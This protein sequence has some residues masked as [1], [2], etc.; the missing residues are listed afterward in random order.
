MRLPVPPNLHRCE[1]RLARMKISIY[2]P[3]INQ[4]FHFG[5][6]S[7]S[8]IRPTGLFAT[9][10]YTSDA[11]A[12][13]GSR[14]CAF[15]MEPTGTLICFPYDFSDTSPSPCLLPQVFFCWLRT[16]PRGQGQRLD[17]PYHGPEESPCQMALR[18]QQPVI[19]GVFH[20][21]TAC[22]HQPLLQARQRVSDQF[23]IL[24]GS[25]NRRHRFPRL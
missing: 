22:L 24:C 6:L 18:Q 3:Y 1:L 17:P 7:H 20:Q 2:A 23:L 14:V 9:A 21:P 25:T 5:I 13:S 16:L 10:V 11:S 15:G 8:S 19:A 12:P 4:D